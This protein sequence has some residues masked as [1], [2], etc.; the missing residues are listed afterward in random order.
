VDAPSSRVIP[1][2]ATCDRRTLGVLRAATG[3]WNT[4]TSPFGAAAAL[5]RDPQ[6]AIG[7]LMGDVSGGSGGRDA[8]GL[9]GG[10]RGGGGSGE[11]WIGLGD[12]GRIGHGAGAGGGNGFGY[13][14]GAPGA[15]PFG[16]RGS[17][18]SR[19]RRGIAVAPLTCMRMGAMGVLSVCLVVVAEPGQLLLRAG[20]P[21]VPTSPVVLS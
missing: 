17:G 6:S 19:R 5:G 13:G 10:G 11:G 18:V 16:A 14:G 1:V 2:T 15:R 12:I 21:V 3:S 8:L 9:H 20:S 4:P 7:A